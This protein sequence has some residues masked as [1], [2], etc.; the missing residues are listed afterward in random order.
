MRVEGLGFQLSQ[1]FSF[2]IVLSWQINRKSYLC[3]VEEHTWNFRSWCYHSSS[4]LYSQKK[5]FLIRCWSFRSK[6]LNLWLWTSFLWSVWPWSSNRR[7]VGRPSKGPELLWPA[8]SL[9]HEIGT[10]FTSIETI[11]LICIVIKFPKL[12][13]VLLQVV[14]E[15]SGPVLDQEINEMQGLFRPWGTLST[16]FQLLFFSFSQMKMMIRC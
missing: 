12:I 14:D 1:I 13:D 9:L 15:R 3:W 4:H 5:S 2:H 6:H 10:W 8:F 7:V 11:A 16:F